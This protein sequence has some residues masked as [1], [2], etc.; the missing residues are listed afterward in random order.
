MGPCPSRLI[1]KQG[2]QQ[3]RG[4]DKPLQRQQ[5]QQQGIRS[6]S[7]SR[8]VLQAACCQLAAVTAASAGGTTSQAHIGCSRGL[9]L[10]RHPLSKHDPR[11]CKTDV[12]QLSGITICLVPARQ[13]RH[14]E[15]GGGSSSPRAVEPVGANLA[16]QQPVSKPPRCSRQER[17]GSH[18]VHGGI[19]SKA[20]RCSR[21]SCRAHARQAWQM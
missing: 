20:P 7:G 12:L 2:Q 11:T 8:W 10:H 21:S 9:G 17:K 18:G 1:H 3:Q 14:L 15:G 4:A 16:A 19:H 5:T 6:C 13:G